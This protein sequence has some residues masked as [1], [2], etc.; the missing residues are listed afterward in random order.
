MLRTIT[1]AALAVALAAPALAGRLPAGLRRVGI[2]I[3]GGNIDPMVLGRVIEKAMVADMVGEEKRG[4]AFGLYNLAFGI[5]VFPA[6]LLFGLIWNQLGAPA[7]FIISSAISVVA[8][9]LLTTV[10]TGQKITAEQV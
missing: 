1:C 7:A 5:A 9:L 8:A 3:S 10:K 2:I 6:S 4:T